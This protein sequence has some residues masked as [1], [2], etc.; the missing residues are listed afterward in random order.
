MK[1][2]SVVPRLL[3]GL[4]MLLFAFS[5]PQMGTTWAEGDTPEV[6]I[7]EDGKEP[8]P[9]H[10]ESKARLE[11]LAPDYDFG[12]VRSNDVKAISHT[13]V[14][15]SAGEETLVISKVK[16]SCG[17]T[18]AIASAT[19]I[20]PGATASITATLTPKGKFGKQVI[21]VRVNSNDPTNSIQVFKMSGII[22][23][24]WRIIPTQVDIGA[25]GK[26]Q[27]ATKDVVVTSQ[28]MK[29]DP[30]FK[31]KAIKTD[32]PD[33]HAAT[34]EAP[35]QNTEPP[36]NLF[37]DVQRIVRI[38]VT[39]GKTEGEQSHRVHIVTDDPQN[40][41]HTVTVRWK[42]EGD[43]TFVPNKVF[44][45]DARGKKAKRDLTLSSRSGQAF[46]VTSIEIQGS[47][48][49]DDIEVILKPD[50]TPSRKV[51]T[52]SPKI[53]TEAATDTRSGKIMFNTT[54]PEQPVIT[55]PYTA[56]FRK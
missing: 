56:I 30:Q 11:A 48:G 49:N 8:P 18:S 3:V 51:Y 10:P 36:S 32:C 28:Y 16:A 43:L 1:R 19:Q 55:V 14:F 20:A 40:P 34:A 2:V 54:S 22:L 39:A 27:S 21:N 45:S 24:D 46:D 6:E 33:I 50:A 9:P 13:F 35:V 44:V 5:F 4:L 52:I 29:D 41:T 47:K 7:T 15:R 25:M 26:L 38:N 53:V 12:A 37:V 42:V 17:C 31:I 23:S